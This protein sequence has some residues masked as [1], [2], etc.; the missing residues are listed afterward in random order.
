LPAV[1]LLNACATTPIPQ[2]YVAQAQTVTVQLSGNQRDAFHSGPGSTPAIK[3]AAKGGRKG[4]AV[5]FGVCTKPF[6]R[7]GF[8][9]ELLA[10]A[11]WPAALLCSFVAVPIGLVVG[12]VDGAVKQGEG[13][14][15]STDIKQF[16]VVLDDMQR[17]QSL[18]NQ[19]AARFKAE[20]MQHRT[21][22]ESGADLLMELQLNELEFIRAND[23]RLGWRLSACIRFPHP[24][25]H[26][27]ARS[28]RLCH[29]HASAMAPI[30]YW[31]ADD[32]ANLRTELVAGI[33]ALS[34]ALNGALWCGPYETR[35]GLYGELTDACYPASEN[36]PETQHDDPVIQPD[37]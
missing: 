4:M 12:T 27:Q 1:V 26:K 10:E 8:V 20:T 30:E 22:V 37:S 16:K 18:R 33:D 34:R 32:G 7:D 14:L 35:V 3:W 31:L 5:G 36:A 15:S 23:K 9:V 24:L 21:I 19:F 28:H 6:K 25:G 11:F 29:S 2:E 13:G 17:E